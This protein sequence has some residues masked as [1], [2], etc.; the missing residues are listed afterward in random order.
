MAKKKKTK[1][2]NEYKEYNDEMMKEI[3]AFRKEMA[4]FKSSQ[5]QKEEGVTGE[6]PVEQRIDGNE[7]KEN[8]EAKKI[9][10]NVAKGNEVLVSLAKSVGAIADRLN[11]QEKFNGNLVKAIGMAEKVENFAK[12]DAAK[13]EALAKS[14]DP[15]YL[16]SINVQNQVKTAQVLTKLLEKSDH[17]RQDDLLPE[18][19]GTFVPQEQEDNFFGSLIAVGSQPGE[20]VQ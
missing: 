4:D 8:E 9:I 7:P 1:K 6:K 17:S 18:R 2:K 12:E 16:N 14:Q 20:V 13:K 10:G 19:K 5:V 3:K 15:N 11:E